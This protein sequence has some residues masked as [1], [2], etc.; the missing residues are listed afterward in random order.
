MQIVKTKGHLIYSANQGLPTYACLGSCQKVWWD[1]DLP[2]DM[3]ITSKHACP[4][5]GGALTSKIPDGHYV[6][7]T[8]DVG[9]LNKGG[10]AIT[11]AGLNLGRR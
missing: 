6:I 4:Q 7:V 2:K 10:A 9:V 3:A 11:N 1:D 5:C 8:K